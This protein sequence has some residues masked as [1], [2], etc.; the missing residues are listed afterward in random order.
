MVKI[1]WKTGQAKVE[2]NQVEND[3]CKTNWDLIVV[4][5]VTLLKENH[6]TVDYVFI[7]F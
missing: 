5:K 4:S 7:L 6:Y 2:G 3:T 1:T